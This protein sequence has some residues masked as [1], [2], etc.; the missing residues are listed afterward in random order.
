[1]SNS[2][3]IN[4]DF[5][6]Y[7]YNHCNNICLFVNSPNLS[8]I[9]TKTIKQNLQS[10][11]FHMIICADGGIN[12]LHDYILLN[13]TIFIHYIIG[14]LD[15]INKEIQDYY[16]QHG[17]KIIKDLNQDMNDLEKCLHFIQDNIQEKKNIEKILIYGAFGGRV[18]QMMAHF[19]TLKRWN[20]LPLVLLDDMNV[21]Y[22]I[23]PNIQYQIVFNELKDHIEGNSIGIIPLYGKIHEMTTTGLKW[24][25]NHQSLE[26]GELISSSNRLHE[27]NITRI[28]S[29]QS[30]DY[31]LFTC[32]LNS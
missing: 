4:H 2:L 16:E 10:N 27:D 7:N 1:M 28:V 8:N 11:S 9:F 14:D 29:I 31:C 15:S 25:L 20:H 13:P 6:N 21:A 32:Q 22:L 12:H 19:D 30:S 17:T 24:D 5:L 26:F 23:K 3:I 18:D